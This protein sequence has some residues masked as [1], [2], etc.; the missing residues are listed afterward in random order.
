MVNLS[1]MNLYTSYDDSSSSYSSTESPRYS[2]RVFKDGPEE[3][4][5]DDG[6]SAVASRY[7][8]PTPEKQNDDDIVEGFLADEKEM[9]NRTITPAV[10]SAEQSTAF[11]IASPILAPSRSDSVN[12]LSRISANSFNPYGA[13]A[14]T[15]PFAPSG[16][17]T[18]PMPG[19]HTD[20]NTNRKRKSQPKEETAVVV[21]R[22]LRRT[23]Q[24]RVAAQRSRLKKK[25]MFNEL[26]TTVQNFAQENANLKAEVAKLREANAQMRAY[27]V[28]HQQRSM[29]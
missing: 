4:L 9:Q 14:V 6:Y 5:K 21:D 1:P 20:F 15:N 24:N 10:E 25:Q 18:F 2:N 17:V 23:L 27:I 13:Y 29:N 3:F 8:S 12:S 26:E 16:F 11:A 28:A 22:K 19:A 7:L